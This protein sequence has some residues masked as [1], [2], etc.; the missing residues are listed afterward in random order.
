MPSDAHEALKEGLKAVDNVLSFAK[1]GVGKPSTKERSLFVA[2][3][4]LSYAVWENFV[5]DLL[6]KAVEFISANIVPSD[7]PETAKT[8]ISRDATP[9]DLAVDPGWRSLWVARI[10]ERAKG[11]E[12]GDRSFGLLTAD[13]AGVRRLYENA[14]LDPFN[15]LDKPKRDE[16]DGL[17]RVR[18]EIVHTGKAPA[19]FVKADAVGACAGQIY[20]QRGSVVTTFR[21]RSGPQ[22]RMTETASN[23]EK[24]ASWVAT[25]T[26]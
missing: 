20:D 4:A 23:A 21:I 7:V 13:V 1:T 14:G 9:W 17:V 18:G 22:T 11:R 3:V 6:I 5:E 12:D 16:L 10:R 24:S 19:S 15:G 8:F 25:A 2:S 26:P